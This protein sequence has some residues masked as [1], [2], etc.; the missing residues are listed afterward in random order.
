MVGKIMAAALFKGG[1]ECSVTG[2]WMYK[3]LCVLLC[4]QAAAH[5]SKLT[6]QK[7]LEVEMTDLPLE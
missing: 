3:R 7:T 1:L 6:T 5:A 4:L 2:K